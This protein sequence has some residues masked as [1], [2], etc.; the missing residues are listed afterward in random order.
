M[1]SAILGIFVGYLFGTVPFGLVMTK[2]FK[3]PDIR[4]M[5][6]GNI[7]A[8]NVLRTGHKLAAFLTL[9]FDGLKGFV[10]SWL[11]LKLLGPDDILVYGMGLAAIVGHVWPVWLKFRGG[12][13]VAT[14]LGTYLALNPLLA[15]ILIIVWLIMTK[16]FRISSLS[17]L[18][19]FAFAP[20]ISVGLVYRGMAYS[21]LIYFCCAV[22]VLI[23]YTH[24]PNLR[25]LI[26]GEETSLKI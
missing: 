20:L 3:L 19:S 7:G 8:T 24:R 5:G 2:C 21:P 17:A 23:F 6:S 26:T 22:T 18:I 14:A 12:K 15:G 25:R 13:G 10:V 11:G 16:I 4:H 1:F 9:F